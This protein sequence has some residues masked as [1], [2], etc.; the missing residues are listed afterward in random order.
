VEAGD[1]TAAGVLELTGGVGVEVS[2]EAVGYP[3]RC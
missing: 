2:I 3:G 1:N